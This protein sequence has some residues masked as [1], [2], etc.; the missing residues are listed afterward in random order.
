VGRSDVPWSA[1][2]RCLQDNPT[3]EGHGRVEGS[4]G[5]AQV[6]EIKPEYALSS[7]VASSLSLALGIPVYSNET[8]G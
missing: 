3:S 5:S 1:S 6:L 7:G 2:Q 4:Q 8:S